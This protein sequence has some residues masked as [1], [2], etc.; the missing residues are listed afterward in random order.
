MGD[1]RLDSLEDI[2]ANKV[3]AAKDR[4]T[5]KD[6]YDLLHLLRRFD[7]DD[8]ERWASLKAMPIDYENLLI[9][10]ADGHLEGEVLTSGPPDLE[11]FAAFA[12]DLKRRLIEHARAR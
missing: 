11:A 1:V 6:F 9:L 12:H 3:T 4:K 7:L 5:T 10:F 2:V 8:A